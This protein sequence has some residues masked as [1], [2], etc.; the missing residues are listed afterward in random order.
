MYDEKIWEALVEAQTVAHNAHTD[1]INELVNSY[2]DNDA[3]I[4][5]LIDERRWVYQEFTKRINA[6]K[7][8][9]K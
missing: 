9:V 6:L 4:K 2:E 7:A 8:T 1:Q 5:K 3:A